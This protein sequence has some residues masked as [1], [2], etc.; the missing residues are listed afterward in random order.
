MY[1]LSCGNNFVALSFSG[2]IKA[3][4]L[5]PNGRICASIIGISGTVVSSD[6]P[7]GSPF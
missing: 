2:I 1:G 4:A 5:D 3:G 7:Q 6:L